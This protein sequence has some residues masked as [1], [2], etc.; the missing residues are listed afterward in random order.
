VL[1]SQIAMTARGSYRTG[2]EQHLRE[3]R[4][5]ADRTKAARDYERAHKNRAGVLETA[6]REL[7]NA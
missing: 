5:H 4:D 7:S 3:T 1:Q 2:L 6:E